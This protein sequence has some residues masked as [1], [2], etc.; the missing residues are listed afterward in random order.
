M[1]Y[2]L[3]TLAISGVITLLLIMIKGGAVIID[4][5]G[6]LADNAERPYVENIGGHFEDESTV[7]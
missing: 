2:L 4:D 3:T 6:H 7:E 1:V 5:Y